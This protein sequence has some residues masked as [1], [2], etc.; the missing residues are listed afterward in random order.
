M[1]DRGDHIAT[2]YNSEFNSG[3]VDLFTILLIIW[4]RKFIVLFTLVLGVVAAFLLI[5]SVQPRYTA[6][7]SILIHLDADYLSPD[8]LLKQKKTSIFDIGPIL[9]EIEFLKSRKMAARVVDKLNLINDPHFRLRQNKNEMSLKQA[10]DNLFRSL[11]VEGKDFQ[12]LPP[13]AIDPEVS[14]AV[15]HL[16]DSLNVFSIPGSLAVKIS[17][18]STDS[19]KSAQIVNTYIDEYIDLKQSEK[20]K[21]QERI[22]YWLDNRLKTLRKNL[23]DVETEIEQFKIQ[24][25]LNPDK[26][27]AVT[28]RQIV[29]L[30]DQYSQAKEDYN[31]L[32]SQMDQLSKAG[33]ESLLS[34][35][36]S[37][38]LNTSFIRQLQS[39]KIELETRSN[40]LANRY[41]PKHPAM[42]K[43]QTE[44]NEVNSAIDSEYQKMKNIVRNELNASKKRVQ[45]IEKSINGEIIAENQDGEALAQLN[46]LER[47]AEASRLVLKTFMEA[48][49][50]SLGKTDLLESNID[51]ISYA[52]RP[53]ESSYPNKTLLLSLSVF[54]SLLLGVFL[55][56]IAERI[57]LMSHT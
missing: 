14:A 24:N 19:K 4:R 55:A 48:Y 57:R 43:V 33:N 27:E 2:S 1:V 7:G 15:T 17:F 5:S 10:S 40:D 44:L 39:Q 34:T 31:K 8:Q 38:T 37:T 45:E 12:T 51:V 54:V 13:E 28:I 25:K 16:V 52:T 20:I 6:E 50:R 35:I 9:T 29:S 49:K 56:F 3:D 53:I 18:T 41:G 22:T 32:Q 42:I 46:D 21:E 47:E 36:N 30:N 23:L 11:T 26:Q